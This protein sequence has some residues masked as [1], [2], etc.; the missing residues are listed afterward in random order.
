MGLGII[1]TAVSTALSVATSL[2]MGYVQA[3]N[4]RAQGEAQRKMAEYNA[5]LAEN[6]A[7]SERQMGK[8]KE[9]LGQVRASQVRAKRKRLQAS[10]R[11]QYAKSGVT[12]TAGTPLLVESEEA[13]R[14][15]MATMDEM[16][17]GRMERRE[18]DLNAQQYDYRASYNRWQGNVA[19]ETAKSNAKNYI[20]GGWVSAGTQLVGGLGKMAGQAFSQQAP[21]QPVQQDF[22]S[23]FNNMWSVNNR[24]GNL[25]LNTSPYEIPSYYESVS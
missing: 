14:T 13:M 25:R 18:H 5:K 6:Q 20:I 10:Q 4:A 11:A 2:T 21:Q 12:A 23:Q 3:R 17:Q 1:F 22:G 7:T 16:W 9:D 24:S 19:M 8:Y 15:E